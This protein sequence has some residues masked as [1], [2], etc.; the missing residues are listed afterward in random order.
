[1]VTKLL[2]NIYQT[3]DHFRIPLFCGIKETVQVVCEKNPVHF[4]FFWFALVEQALP[5]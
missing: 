5:G 3:Y 2:T 1:M 4:P